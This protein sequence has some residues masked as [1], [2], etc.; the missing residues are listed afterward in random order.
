L[1]NQHIFTNR[2]AAAVERKESAATFLE[3]AVLSVLAIASVL[4]CPAPARDGAT[5]R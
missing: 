5:G 3:R 4:A 1:F 2:G